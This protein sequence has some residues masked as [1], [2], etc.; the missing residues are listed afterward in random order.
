MNECLKMC[1]QH[2]YEEDDYIPASPAKEQPVPQAAGQQTKAD[3]PSSTE[4]QV[5]TD[6]VETTATTEGTLT[7]STTEKSIATAVGQSTHAVIETL[8]K[9]QAGEARQQHKKKKRR[10]IDDV[11]ST[12]KSE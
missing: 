2:L 12:K 7:E 9:Q 3:T 11:S 8:E 1:S 5:Q 4:E 6:A 10:K